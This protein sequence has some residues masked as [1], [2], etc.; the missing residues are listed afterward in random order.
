[1]RFNA[2]SF[3]RIALGLLLAGTVIAFAAFHSGPIQAAAASPGATSCGLKGTYGYV[4]TGNT[5]NF[6]PIGYS[7]GV[8]ST[9]GTI[10]FDGEGHW[11][12]HEEVV[13]N[14]QHLDDQTYNG[15]YTLHPDCTFTAPADPTE[16]F[17]G[18]IDGVVVDQ[19][20]QIR[21]INT[22]PGLA[23]SYASMIKVKTQ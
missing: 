6:N 19:G 17:V 21:A 4:G 7:E 18:G 5:Y 23:L 8:M 13:V 9:V 12:S 15:S 3:R 10:T 11:S 22:I 20:N 14:G 16:I 2:P 1:M